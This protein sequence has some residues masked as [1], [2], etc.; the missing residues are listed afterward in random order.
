M[1]AT[2]ILHAVLVISGVV[3]ALLVMGAFW[4]RLSGWP[5]LARAFPDKPDQLALARHR[6]RARIGKQVGA[7]VRCWLRLEPCV[8]GLRVIRVR[9]IDFDPYV[10]FVPWNE[11]QTE[12][13]SG[14][15]LRPNF[16]GRV[17]LVVGDP[18]IGCIEISADTAQ[19]LA[20]VSNG[21][22]ALPEEPWTKFE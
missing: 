6:E 7:G 12:K 17:T 18:Q 14:I 9:S 4:S 5:V 22:L 3:V 16:F 10:I 15:G 1:Q 19:E 20:K 21:A 8:A 13:R 2:G 11:I